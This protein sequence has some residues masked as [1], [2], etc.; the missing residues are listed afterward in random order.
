LGEIV[1]KRILLVANKT[2]RDMP[3][4][5]AIREQ[6]SAMD[7]SAVVQI[8][9][10]DGNL[11]RSAIIFRP[12][13]V[14][15]FPM[16]SLGVSRLLYLLKLY[17]GCR[18]VCLR[19]EG[20]INAKSAKA[21]ADHIGYDR[22]GSRLIDAELFWAAGPAQIIGDGLIAQGKIS[23]PD[24]IKYF[25]YPRLERYFEKRTAPTGKIISALAPFGM[26][27][28]AQTVLIATGFHFAN[29]GRAEIFRAGDLDATRRLPELLSLVD[30]VKTFRQQWITAIRNSARSN[31]NILF[32]LKKHPL[33]KPGDYAS[34]AVEPNVVVIS[35]NVA[36]DDLIERSGALIHYGSTVVADAYLAKVP[37]VYA[38]S[39][40]STL[41]EYMSDLGWPSSLSVNINDLESA[42][43]KFSAGE[44]NGDT[45]NDI[46]KILEWN[47]N[48][49]PGVDYKPSRD[50]AAFLLANE[51]GQRI[52]FWHKYMWLSLFWYAGVKAKQLLGR[53]VRH[54]SPDAA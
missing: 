24:R 4:M 23:S 30:K 42:I 35:E 28:P 25:G 7:P 3:I 10:F 22:Y 29:Y 37:T 36:I 48:I 16:T 2:D 27:A 38:Y 40:D 18:I 21:V 11:M 49:R 5:S 54:P 13:T 31:R 1:L 41:Q 32:V 43:Q 14:L 9:P 46:E 33:E 45:T 12:D 51:R 39:S 17:F 8:V 15:I 19:A 44:L 26:F 6:I 50:I 53:F 34:L 20:V 47:F 52:P